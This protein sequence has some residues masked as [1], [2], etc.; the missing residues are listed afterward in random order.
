MIIAPLSILLV[1][2][3]EMS[4]KSLCTFLSS[5]GFQVRPFLNPI[6][7]LKS[8]METDYQFIVTDYSMPEL[9]GIQLIEK[10]RKIQPQICTILYTGYASKVFEQAQILK[11]VD[12][13]LTK[14][15]RIRTLIEI[16]D[17]TLKPKTT[18]EQ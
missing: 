13:F 1:D 11:E 10:L 5:E 2:N 8:A 14:P 6:E 3:D 15:L 9:T 17:Q 7:A 16:F 4:L 12:Y 18:E